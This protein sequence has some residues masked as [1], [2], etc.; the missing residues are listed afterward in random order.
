MRQMALDHRWFPA[1][2]TISENGNVEEELKIIH[3]WIAD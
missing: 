1:G 2:I 3:S